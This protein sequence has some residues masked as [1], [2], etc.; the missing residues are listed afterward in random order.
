M[1]QKEA[2]PLLRSIIKRNMVVSNEYFEQ[3]HPSFLNVV[4]KKR[5]TLD[6]LKKFGSERERAVDKI[7]F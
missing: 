5:W 4:G 2:E 7:K 3:K 1:E 6:T